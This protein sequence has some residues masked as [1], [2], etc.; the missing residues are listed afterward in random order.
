MNAQGNDINDNLN[1]L[2]G[3]TQGLLDAT[4]NATE[5]TVIEARNRLKSALAAA[6]ETCARVKAKAIDGAKATDK[7]VRD[8]PWQSVGVAFGVGALLGYLLSRR[9]RD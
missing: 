4:A 3:D 9:N 2:A 1:Q 7:L 5:D 8:N 6:G